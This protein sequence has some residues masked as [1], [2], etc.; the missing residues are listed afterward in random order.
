MLDAEAMILYGGLDLEICEMFA[1]VLDY[2][3]NFVLVETAQMSC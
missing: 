2:A 3:V 1:L